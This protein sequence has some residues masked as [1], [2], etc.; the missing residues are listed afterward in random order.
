MTPKWL[1]V[2]REANRKGPGV[3]NRLGT[4]MFGEGMKK[5]DLDRALTLLE[6]TGLI[7]ARDTERAPYMVSVTSSGDRLARGA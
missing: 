5:I 2:L 7:E 6:S 1:V 3:R 4:V